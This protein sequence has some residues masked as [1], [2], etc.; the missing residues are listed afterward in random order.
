MT[1]P[2]RALIVD[3]EPLARR[4]LRGMLA[5]ER[6]IEIVGEAGSGNAAVKAII[7]HRP[8]LVFLD[9][10]MPELNGFE[11]LRATAERHQ[12]LVVFVTA[13]DEH[14]IRAFDVQAADYILK[15]VVETRFREAVQRAVRRLREQPRAEIARELARLLE[16]VGKPEQSPRLPIRRDGRVLFV[17]TA[18]ITRIESDGDFVRVHAGADSHTVRET[19]AEMEARLPSPPFVRVH[20]S[21]IV[22][23]GRIREIQPWFKGDYVV[24][25]T[26]GSKIRTGRTY[27]EAVQ[28]LMK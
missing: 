15:P 1:T 16:T 18:D 28:R 27:R 23:A 19:M 26:D 7:H 24:I 17:N 5:D 12:P 8:D 22:N 25:L 11:V 4:R 3:D 21:A 13:F 14:A 10:Q 6:D 20:R 9:V 2:V